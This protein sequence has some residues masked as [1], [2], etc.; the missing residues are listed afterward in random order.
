M[1]GDFPQSVIDR[2]NHLGVLGTELLKHLKMDDLNVS[3][4][5]LSNQ[6]YY[7]E[8]V[9]KCGDV[10]RS[11]AVNLL[12][13]RA[14][15]HMQLDDVD[16]M[17]IADITLLPY[18][19]TPDGSKQWSRDIIDIRNDPEKEFH[20]RPFPVKKSTGPGKKTNIWFSDVWKDLCKT[21]KARADSFVYHSK[22]M[23]GWT[24][25]M[26]T[27]Y[28]LYSK[29]LSRFGSFS[30]E[31]MVRILNDRDGSKVLNMLVK[32]TGNNNTDLGSHLA[33]VVCL[34]GMPIGAIDEAEKARERC[35]KS[36]ENT[37]K[38]DELTLRKHIRWIIDYELD[39][40]EYQPDPGGETWVSR[41]LWVTNGGHSKVLSQIEKSF[42][43]PDAKERFYRKSAI[44]NYNKNAIFEWSGRTYVTTAT[45]PE[46]GKEGRLLLSCDTN[47]YCA[48][49]H[50]LHPV[51]KAWKNK[52]V[53]LDPGFD[54]QATIID[55]VRQLSGSLN[56][57]FDFDA[58]DTQHSI[59]AQ[60][61]C[62]DELCDKIGFNV[63]MSNK[64]SNSF[65]KMDIY[66]K[67]VKVGRAR[68]S[69][70][71][72]H[73]ATTFI[74]TIL[75][76]AYMK[77]AMGDDWY[78]IESMHAGDDV[79]AKLKSIEQLDSLFDNIK[80]FNMRMNPLKQSIGYNCAE[81]LRICITEEYALGYP[82]RS[83]SKMVCGNWEVEELNQPEQSLNNWMG[84]LNTL[85]NRTR[86]TN[87]HTLLVSSMSRGT[88]LPKR[89]CKELLMNFST[90]KGR[91]LINNVPV[92]KGYSINRKMPPEELEKKIVVPEG[93]GN[94]ATTDYLS[95]CVTEVEKIAM[96]MTHVD[97]AKR[98]TTASYAKNQ[99]IKDQTVE[100]IDIEL[101][102]MKDVL[103]KGMVLFSERRNFRR[104]DRG[105]L[106]K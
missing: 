103:T 64:L 11:L 6:M 10:K 33:E 104:K 28:I 40:E 77:M 7:L 98:M 13:L 23:E 8:K 25:D 100:D 37:V 83:L 53:I 101:I 86:S 99:S 92:W 39:M 80:S 91:P 71:T 48:F 79:Y 102:R 84:A 20:I 15:I 1:S 44:E 54:S 58:F 19:K 22:K 36:K 70:M 82:A 76:G 2:S 16:L 49:H 17:R 47:T 45:K 46:V 105:V 29:A 73:R 9:F 52:R 68:H 61:I 90:L 95:N 87:V 24:N 18:D 34:F 60:Q 69:L 66:S 42:Q 75:N 26:A 56:A 51:E 5:A 21:E 50:L 63:V 55:K 65:N 67:G 78:N 41:W 93:Y 97:L 81:F 43:I 30:E 38:F 96:D 89:Q 74:N 88:R 72:G 27:C 12:V 14:A 106:L 94:R 35:D 32:A 62:I 57:M 85:R 4:D 31:L 59:R 3:S